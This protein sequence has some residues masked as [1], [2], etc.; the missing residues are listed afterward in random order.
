MKKIIFVFSILCICTSCKW[1]LPELK[2]YKHGS[3]VI[4]ERDNK[5]YPTI[6]I[7]VDGGNDPNKEGQCWMQKNLEYELTEDDD[8]NAYCYDTLPQY[9]DTYGYLYNWAAAMKAGEEGIRGICP[10]GWHIPTKAEFEQLERSVGD[11]AYNLAREGDCSESTN[12]SQFT[13]LFG[14]Y[15]LRYE[16]D[17]Y[18]N[19]IEGTTNCEGV[20]ASF[21]SSTERTTTESWLL[22]IY[23]NQDSPMYVIIDDEHKNAA[24]SIRCICDQ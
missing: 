1:T 2:N 8:G 15:R 20:R 16:N 17:D 19:N 23:K 13:A 21:W 24:L 9:C 12:Q 18:R 3:P 22:L 10:K 7:D 6:W 11:D 5:E 14:G 4:D